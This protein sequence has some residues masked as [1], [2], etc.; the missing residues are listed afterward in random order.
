MLK[1]V[2]RKFKKH[3]SPDAFAAFAQVET[4]ARALARELFFVSAGEIDQDPVRR[5]AAIDVL[6]GALVGEAANKLKADG[7][8]DEAAAIAAELAA[9]RGRA[10]FSAE[11]SE[12]AS[13][14]PEGG[15][16]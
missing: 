16:A 15:R 13:R 6:F 10:A 8:S 12:L 4:G 1:S 14:M 11:W 2:M 7:A 5:D 3:K 9:E